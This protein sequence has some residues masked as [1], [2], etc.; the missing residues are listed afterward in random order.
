[1]VDSFY[2][3]QE[4]LILASLG[5][6]LW[7]V[8]FS[9]IQAKAALFV[10]FLWRFIVFFI[11]ILSINASYASIVFCVMLFLFLFFC[12]RLSIDAQIKAAE[13][14]YIGAFY[15]LVP[16]HTYWG[17]FQ[18]IFMPWHISNYE[19]RVLVNGDSFWCVHRG[20]FKRLDKKKFQWKDAAIWIPL[21]RELTKEEIDIANSYV[22]KTCIYGIRDC[23]NLMVA[24][25][26][27]NFIQKVK[28]G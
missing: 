5:V 25:N 27:N 10:M 19:T 16:I 14:T 12:F 20:I 23:R 28:N 7:F 13:K 21:G 2:G 9:K 11:N 1:M 8:D 26:P 6:S 18:K 3:I 24:G 22:G 15:V 4:L 17:L